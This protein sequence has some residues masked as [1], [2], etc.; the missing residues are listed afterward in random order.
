MAVVKIP[1]L[2]GATIDGIDVGGFISAKFL[3]SPAETKQLFDNASDFKFRDDDIML[4]AYPK[5]GTHLIF[6]ILMSVLTK[7]AKP[8][9]PH[10]LMTMLEC[11]SP[12]DIDKLPSPRVINSHFPYRYLPVKDMRAEQIKTVLC[13]RNPKDTAVS[14]Y[15]HM[16][17]IKHYSYDGK[18]EDWLPVYIQGKMEYGKYTDYLTEWENAIKEGIGFPLH[19]VYYENIKLNGHDEIDKLAKFLGVEL[20]GA[21]KQD[22]MKA[23]SFESMASKEIPEDIASNFFKTHFRIFRKGEIGD[24]KNWFTD[25]QNTLFEEVWKQEMKHSTIF[26]FIYTDPRV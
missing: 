5:T 14:Y 10:K 20:D 11:E 7:S 18:W 15:N 24:W 19:V 4:C 6:D 13:C 3:K 17:G 23:C 26:E 12:E 8:D 16:H 9:A 21:L 2:G 25:E 1:D 22:I